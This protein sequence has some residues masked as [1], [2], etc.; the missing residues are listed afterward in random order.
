MKDPNNYAAQLNNEKQMEEW[1]QNILNKKRD[2]TLDELCENMPVAFKKYMQHVR[3]LKFDEKPN[4]K[5][6]R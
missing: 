1:S 6:L 4:Y 3:E 2:T 5:Y